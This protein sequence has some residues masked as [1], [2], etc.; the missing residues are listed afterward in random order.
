MVRFV[1]NRRWTFILALCAGLTW[2]SLAHHPAIAGGDD[3]SGSVIGE[4]TDPGLPGGGDPDVPTG[5]G[6]N[7]R[8]G[9]LQRGGVINLGAPNAGDGRASSSVWMMRLRIVLQSLR[10][11]YFRF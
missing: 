5:P 11:F 4:P 1:S 9:K 10:G 8:G 7:G 3:K 2:C 6:K